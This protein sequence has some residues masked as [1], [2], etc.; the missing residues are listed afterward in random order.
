MRGAFQLIHFAVIIIYGCQCQI[1]FANVYASVAA[2]GD[3]EIRFPTAVVGTRGIDKVLVFLPGIVGQ[4][5][6]YGVNAITGSSERG[7][8]S[9]T[10]ECAA[11]I[12][13]IGARIKFTLVYQQA[14]IHRER[15]V[16]NGQ[17]RR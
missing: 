3:W 7:S 4:G 9:P 13:P 8:G 11:D 1:I 15:N 14:Y 16:F 2:R 6:G 12:N 17:C 5:N 10:V